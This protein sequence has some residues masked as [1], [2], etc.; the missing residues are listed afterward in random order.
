M[1]RNEEG[2]GRALAESGLPRDEVFITTK[3]EQRPA[4]ARRGRR[5]RSTRACERLGTRLRR[6]V[7][8][9]L[10]ARRGRPLRRDLAAFEKLLAEGRTRSIGVS[11]FTV[12]PAE[13]AGRGDRHRARRS[14]RSSC[15]RDF[16]QA[17]L[18][19][20]HAEHGIATEAWS[21][22]G[23]GERLL[24]DPVLVGLAAEAR[25]H[26]RAG[27]AALARAA[28]QH[29]RS[30]SPC[31]PERMRENIDVFDFELSA[32][33]DVQ[34][35]SA[36][37]RGTAAAGPEPRHLRLTDAGA[38]GPRQRCPRVRASRYRLAREC[39]VRDRQRAT[40]SVTF[41]GHFV[42]TRAATPECRGRARRC[43]HMSLRTA[44]GG[45]RASRQYGPRT[46]LDRCDGRTSVRRPR[47]RAR[48][49]VAVRTVPR[50]LVARP[51][52]RRPSRRP[53]VR[54]RRRRR[55]LD[56]RGAQ[57]RLPARDPRRGR[58]RHDPARRVR[59][60]ARGGAAGRGR[61]ASAWT[62]RVPRPRRR[63]DRVRLPL[64]R[65]IAAAIRRHRPELV[66][67]ANHHRGGPA[68][69]STWPTT[70]SSGGRRSTRSRDAGNRWLFPELGLDPWRGVRWVAA[71]RRPTRVTPSTSARPS[72][73]GV[74]SL[75]AHAAYLA[76]LGGDMAEPEIRFYGVRRVRGR[77]AARREPRRGLRADHPLVG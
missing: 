14:T 22:L 5:A 7:P 41:A 20:Y 30:R 34:A 74:A 65:D 71:S 68:T 28:R 18:R 24:D 8:D 23:Q 66:V 77:A 27:G 32:G 54:R 40:P 26:P 69:T 70:A 64:R 11:N 1:Y 21:P 13:P 37:D 45:F 31:T 29:R 43:D 10:A 75:E 56:R 53:R 38:D 35:I 17:E 2:V 19:A 36:L 55:P 46:P 73:A 58:D 61:R 49:V 60:V 3:L 15:T 59:P 50:R 67:I 52:R 76:A 42:P 9:P 48:I 12:R 57:R 62:R 4:T 6:P 44:G 33:D 16:A 63:D 51:R 25:Q 72:T 39:D 47:R